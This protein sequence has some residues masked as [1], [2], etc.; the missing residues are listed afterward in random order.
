MTAEEGLTLL[1]F[2]N[3]ILSGGLLAIGFSVGI[4][5]GRG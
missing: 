1:M 5:V 3:G 4:M 2:L